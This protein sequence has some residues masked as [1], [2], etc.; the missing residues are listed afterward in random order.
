MI[1]IPE[2]L[3]Q[4][5]MQMTGLS[6]KE[7]EKILCKSVSEMNNGPIFKAQAPKKKGK[8]SPKPKYDEENYPHF[9][10]SDNIKKYTVRVSLKGITPVVWRKFECPSNISLRHLTEL[11]IP[12]M[13]WENEHLNQ[14]EIGQ[15]TYYVPFYQ[16][17]SDNDWGDH[18][19]QEEYMLSDILCEKGK[20]IRWEYDFGDSWKHE[21]RLSEIGEYM[22]D[23]PHD[24]V[25]KSGKRVCPPEDCGGVWG[26]QELLE[27]HEK[28]K[29]HK[30][31]TSEEKEHLEWYGIDNNYDPD[32]DFDEYECMDICDDFSWD[33][34][35]A[36]PKVTSGEDAIKSTGMGEELLK[37]IGDVEPMTI[38]PLYDEVLSLAFR[39]RELE[40]WVDLDDS[41]VYAVKMNDGSEM[42]I[43]TMGNAG[44]M[45]DVQF[46]DGAESF[47]QYLYFMKG[48][49]MPH[50]D[51]IDAHNW[52]D[53]ASI[54]FL[55]NVEEAAD[56]KNFVRIKQ[57]ADTHNEP[58][59]DDSGYPLIQR[60]CPHRYQSQMLNDEQ[61]LLRL[62]EA[63]EAVVWLSQQLLD[64]E[65]LADLGFVDGKYPTE[66][67]GKV[68]PLVIKTHEGYKL[69]RT[70]LPGLT[71]NY[72]T[73]TL[74]ASE[75][76]PL[77]FLQ[78]SGAQ[79]CRLIHVPG[80]VGSEDDRENAY[81]AL[82]FVCIDKNDEKASITEVCEMSDDYERDV[83]RQYINKVKKEGLFPQ[84]IITDHPRTEAL[85]RDF[86]RSLGIILELKRTRIP[87]LTRICKYM[88][89]IDD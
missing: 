15:D 70:K 17:D 38:S 75:L 8:R 1:Q 16:H 78:K 76:Q 49:E 37:E 73:I 24:I 77:R 31:L 56:P 9:L 68:V 33:D 61:G 79:Y 54:L 80:L 12:L 42:Y 82:V 48:Q 10:P 86:C 65:D 36:T 3:L 51:L 89:E 21:I 20:T 45:K 7:A 46:Y 69:E 30:R 29:S 87:E 62:K 41:D 22:V 72:P 43:A 35:D 57:W 34:D 13:G 40:P 26:Y 52:A 60:Y 53:Y 58:I 27:L 39:L 67:G 55:D 4:G 88:Y 81:S 11:L 84:R 14:I 74:P 18:R 32:E 25:F 66:R 23:E 6:R 5:F 85:L 63:L 50:F 59:N 44:G 47:Q 2:D 19:Y 64:S 71:K 28:R 83:M